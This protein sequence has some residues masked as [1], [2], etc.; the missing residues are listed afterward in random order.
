MREI[1][2]AWKKYIP[3]CIS[4]FLLFLA[5]RYWDSAVNLFALALD[6]ATPL[7]LGLVLAYLLNIIMSF[8]E[9]V[10]LKKLNGKSYQRVIAI[11]LSFVT[12]V[13]I[14]GGVINLVLPE[15]VKSIKQILSSIPGA[16]S[17]LEHYISNNEDLMA[18]IGQ[19]DLS[20][21]KVMQHFSKI[22]D[23]LIAGLNGVMG[24]FVSIISMTVSMIVTI[25]LAAIFAVYLLSGK[26]KLKNQ[27]RI[28][29]AT[30]APKKLSK[31]KYFYHT[32]DESFHNFIVGQCTE[33]LILGSLCMIGMAVIGLPYAF[34]IGTLIGVTALIPIAGAY[35]GGGIGA[36]LIV[37][38]SPVKALVFLIFLVLLQQIEGNLIYPRV[39]GKSI[40]LPAI[41]VLTAITVGGGV[42]GIVGMLVAVPL[43]S[44]CYRMVRD[45][46]G[47][48]KKVTK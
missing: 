36:L 22:S 7:L 2:Q 14:L 32:L 34:M 24:S 37:M 15:L 19:L 6:A 1:N 47:R 11:L 35:I 38:V 4:L 17:R 40:G 23:V 48:R 43:A 45:D 31:V 25:A 18:V 41:W 10:L 30:Y 16:L 46:V 42:S 39:V 27:C 5:V 9:K 8:Y 44:A 33:A 13:V 28:L 20:S 26:E 12:L 29:L 3:L 21:D